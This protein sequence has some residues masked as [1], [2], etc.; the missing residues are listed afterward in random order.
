MIRDCLAEYV[1]ER[2]H[3]RFWLDDR[4]Q[5]VFAGVVFCRGFWLTL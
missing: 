3:N 4:E 5:L 1:D 2:S